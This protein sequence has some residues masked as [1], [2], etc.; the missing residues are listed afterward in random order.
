[1]DSMRQRPAYESGQ[2]YARAKLTPNWG[3]LWVSG[4][5]D[6]FLRGYEEGLSD[7]AAVRTEPARAP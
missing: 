4:R 5:Y 7:R 1:M 6:E 3:A 2:H